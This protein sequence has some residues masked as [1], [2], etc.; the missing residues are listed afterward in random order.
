MQ[1]LDAVPVG[2]VLIR[3]RIRIYKFNQKADHDDSFPNSIQGN[4][5]ENLIIL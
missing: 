5:P 4:P 2:Y 3:I 1:L